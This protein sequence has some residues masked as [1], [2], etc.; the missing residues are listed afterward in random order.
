MCPALISN[1][2]RLTSD[3]V[4]VTRSDVVEF[5]EERNE[6]VSSSTRVKVTISEI[7]S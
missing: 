3:D 6:V 4:E 2:K 5:I 7:K 1:P